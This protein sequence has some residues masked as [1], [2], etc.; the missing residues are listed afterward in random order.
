MSNQPEDRFVDELVMRDLT[1]SKADFSDDDI[2]FA[3]HNPEVLRKLADPLEFKKRYILVILAVAAGLAVMSK[4][5][6]YTQLLADQ[7]VAHDLLTNVAFAVS[8]EL[9]GAALV[10]FVMEIAFQRRLER[11]QALIT[12]LMA[13]RRHRDQ[14]DP[15]EPTHPSAEQDESAGGTIGR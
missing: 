7:A 10:A 15:Q 4:V 3:R 1:T 2:E 6:E 14:D 11:N 12:A 13:E 9:L 5:I 8:M